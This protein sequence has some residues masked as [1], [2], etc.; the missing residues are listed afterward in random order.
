MNTIVVLGLNLSHD[1]SACI[2]KDGKIYAAEE[3]RW[4]KIKHNTID[5][6]DDFLFPTNALEYV[7][8]ESKTKIEDLSKVVCVSM[9]KNDFIGD[10]IK[11]RE[12][13]KNFEEVEYISHH[14]AHILSGYLISPFKE[15][16]GLCLDGAGSMIGLDYNLRERITGYYLRNDDITKIYSNFDKIKINDGKILKLKN[17]LGIFYYNF[18][19]RCIPIGDEAEGSMMALSSFARSDKYYNEIKSLIELYPNGLFQI[20]HP[21]ATKTN[22]T[23]KIGKYN[24]DRTSVNKIPF[25]ERANLAYAVQKVFEETLIYILNYLYSLTN[26]KN[27]VI[28]GGCA[29]NSK[30]NGEIKKNTSFENIY[31]PPAPNDGG[32]ALGA[33]LYAWNILMKKERINTPVKV[34]WGPKIQELTKTEKEK[35]TNNNIEVIECSGSEIYFKTAKL[36]S[37]KKVVIWARGG[38]EFGPR[39]LGYRSIIGHPGDKDLSIRINEIKKRAEYRPLAPS[40]LKEKF[41]EF[42]YGDADYY[43]NKV[44]FVKD[45]KL[46]CGITH[47][48]GS[49]RVQLVCKENEFY[50]L[51]TEFYKATKLPVIINTSLNLKGIPIAK[52]K[53]DVLNIFY[54]L[55]VDAAVI[56]NTIL[57]K[58]RVYYKSEDKLYKINAYDTEKVKKAV[59]FIEDLYKDRKRDQGTDFISHP[60]DVVDIIQNEFNVHLND[61]YIIIALLHDALWIDFENTKRKIIENFGE[62]IYTKVEKLTKPHIL[63]Q[64]KKKVDDSKIFFEKISKLNNELLIIKFADRLN[65]LREVQFSSKEKQDR[66]RKETYEMY[67]NLLIKNKKEDIFGKIYNIFKLEKD[68]IN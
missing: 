15:A 57:I 28:S 22:D 31:I 12:E 32:I 8:N 61:D 51:I 47:K 40:I 13:L 24:W 55:D 39:A 36:L 54:D 26:V 56:G 9:S 7:L 25:E 21:F 20:K 14:K 5:R 27:L 4:T 53:E 37:E 50:K 2:I 65:N 43:M 34:D 29:L 44:A 35:A 48:D 46:L 23:Y 30:F 59:E 3:E 62:D 17:S 6:K 19:K 68:K 63:E 66:F 60:L 41:E 45:K 16:V 58:K 52:D 1:T 10:N 38:M 64:R 67:V 42:F 49:A 11:A 33:A 18:A